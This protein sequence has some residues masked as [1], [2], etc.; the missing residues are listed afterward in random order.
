MT[1]YRYRGR[2]VDE[3]EAL[4]ADG[5]LLDGFSMLVPT[6]LRDA[7]PPLR[8]TDADGGTAGLHR[9]GPRVTADAAMRD[10]KQ[11]AYD[12]YLHDVTNA[13]RGSQPREIEVKLLTGD[14]RED[15]DAAY[16]EYVTNAWR[17]P[18]DSGKW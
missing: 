1:K 7:L 14:A 9:P 5:V 6:A 3:A 17:G 16:L 12:A 8:V 4:G 13:W 2:D 18:R 11:A 15:A 10:A